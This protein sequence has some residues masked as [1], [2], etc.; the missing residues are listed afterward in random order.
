MKKELLEAQR[1]KT[2]VFFLEQTDRHSRGR[3]RAKISPRFKNVLRLKEKGKKPRA[4][5]VR[6]GGKVR[7]SSDERPAREGL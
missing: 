2:V 5:A 3:N 7:R 4:V 1:V 6:R